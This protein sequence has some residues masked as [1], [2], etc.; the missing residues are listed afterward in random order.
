MKELVCLILPLVICYSKKYF[1]QISG[2]PAI[3]ELLFALIMAVSA[4]I[5]ANWF[6][7]N[8]GKKLLSLI[9]SNPALAIGGLAGIF[10]LPILLFLFASQS[11]D[12]WMVLLCG[13]LAG[14]LGNH[15]LEKISFPKTRAF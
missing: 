10:L 1:A 8:F 3:T 7:E 6:L 4:G 15:L 5:L 11:G 13:L 12:L 9:K 14:L 2:F